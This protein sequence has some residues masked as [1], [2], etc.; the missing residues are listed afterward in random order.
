VYILGVLHVL[1]RSRKLQKLVIPLLVAGKA[2]RIPRRSDDFSDR[3]CAVD[4]QSLPDRTAAP[5][6]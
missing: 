5:T 4:R 3:F 1:V 6:W 2:G